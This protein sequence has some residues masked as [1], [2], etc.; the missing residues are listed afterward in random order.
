MSAIF[1]VLT[2]SG[3]LLVAICLSQDAPVRAAQSDSSALASSAAE[4]N[5]LLSAETADSKSSTAQLVDDKTYI[6]R[7]TLDLLGRSPTPE[8]VTAFVLD[9]S[10]A[11]RAQLVESLLADPQF[12][13]NWG[14]YFR[15]VILYRKSEDRALI[16]APAIF[17][18]LQT[19]LNENRS[20][21]KIATAFITA[22]GNV[23]E[24]GET[25]IIFA[26]QGRPEETVSE[27][28]RI[29]M[30]VQIQCAQCHDHPTD[31]WKREQFHELAAFFPRVAVRPIRDSMGREFQ[32]VAD[33][34]PMGPRRPGNDNRFRGSPQHYMPNLEDPQDKG[35]VMSPVFFVTG[36]KLSTSA[37]D[38]Q[39]RESLAKWVTSP[40]NEW[41]SKSIVNRLWGELV[42][43]GFFEPLDDLGPDRTPSAPQTLD[44]LA[45]H[46]VSSGH[47]VK[48][49]FRVIMA[50]D[51]YQRQVRTRRNPDETPFAASA[52][53][54]L[55]SDQLF[56]NLQN[57]LGLPDQLGPPRGEMAKG[58]GAGPARR[59]AG[60]LRFQFQQTFGYDPSD[61]R[62]EVTT[63]IPQALA[64]MNAG[65]INNAVTARPGTRLS[66]LMSEIS[67]DKTLIG[68]L[69]LIAL[70][71]EPSDEELKT[72]LG[73]VKKT[74]NR[75]E[76]YEDILWSLINT[77]EFR[78]RN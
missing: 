55:R 78:Y 19:A 15:D 65:Y 73:Y 42:G 60:D 67:D 35:T 43:E 57:V 14:R 72:C 3:C 1:R 22:E 50:T 20:W 36:D 32:V 11:K 27:I 2:T 44:Y 69:Y 68:E 17:T 63:S 30:G 41:F 5:R 49:L 46:F 48:N 56:T 7:T 12:G 13:E 66:K 28:S 74:K 10:P 71:R 40:T 24:K 4:T 18:Y 38:N 23:Q 29:F 76:A 34:M 9:P 54:R 59:F 21:D 51:A 70:A 45:K 53:Q 75:N 16:A 77:T 33:D 37:N 61:R 47:D 6:R 64:M 39:R 31:R 8:E 58:A 52:A 26:Q 25:G 62:D